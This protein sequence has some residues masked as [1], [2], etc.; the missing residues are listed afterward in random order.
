VAIGKEKLDNAARNMSA[1]PRLLNTTV[2]YRHT[3][4]QSK[5]VEVTETQGRK[6]V[7]NMEKLNAM[8]ERKVMAVREIADKQL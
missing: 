3:S 5:I 8:D 1:D 6:I 2:K 4:T 7:I